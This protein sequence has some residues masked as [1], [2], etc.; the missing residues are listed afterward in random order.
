MES[1]LLVLMITAASLGFVHTI[2]GPDHYLPFIVMAKAR[3]WSMRKTLWITALCGGG[4]VL[5][6]ILL[7]F[8]GILLGIGLQNLVNIESSRGN[9]AA[10]ALLFF[11]LAYFI[12][13][14]WRAIRNKP[15]KHMHH[16]TNGT[17]HEHMHSHKMEHNHVHSDKKMSVTPWILF[18][19][20]VL[21][22]CEPLIPL[23]MYPAAEHSAMGVAGVSLV[24]GL[25][26]IATMI[27]AVSILT[28]GIKIVQLQK[29]EKYA[30]AI[31]GATISLSGFGIIF[32]G[33]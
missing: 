28:Y 3:G 26:T 30:H 23:L 10:W 19:I 11:G 14:I 27:F 16:H 12:W 22:P 32:L 21:G 6:S 31:A 8:G 4:H 29:L 2:L 25:T 13:G 7:G 24:F 18:L 1:T 15:H 9:L 20:F 33:F 17:V 5:S